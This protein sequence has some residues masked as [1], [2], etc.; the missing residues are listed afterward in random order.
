MPGAF[1]ANALRREAVDR[2]LLNGV[3]SVR[4]RVDAGHFS[5]PGMGVQ[6]SE[7][8][9]INFAAH[10]ARAGTTGAREDFE[11]MLGLLVRA[12]SG[13]AN[14]VFANP[15]DW[16]IDVVVG[17][18]LGRVTVWQA[19][20]F[21]GGV[22]RR[23]QRQISASFDSARKAAAEH[24]YTLER[25]VLCI[26]ASMDGLTLQWWHGWKAGQEQD[27]GVRI[28]LWDE[29]RLRELLLRP[30]AA[31][32][33][34]HYYNP[35]RSDG[36]GD[37]RPAIT[38]PYRGL[39]AF[40]EQD[41]GLFFGRDT[42]T[43]EVLEGMSA[44]L[45]GAGLIV[46]SGVSGAGKSSLLRA[47][48]LPRLRES[49]LSGAAQAASWPCVVFTPG[50]HPLEELAVR[51]A[52]LAGT[53]AS[54]V[55]ERLVADP[56][57]FALTA[58]QAALAAASGASD[59]A[60]QR[61]VLLVID[62]C[63]QLYTSCEGAAEREAFV[64]A[65]H[66]AATGDHLGEGPAALVVLVVRADFEARL[67]DYSQLITAVQERYL[68]TAMTERQLRLAITQ[69]AAA[70]GS[71]VEDDLVQALL[72]EVRT[73]AAGPSPAGA[74]GAGVLPLLSHA[75]DQAWRTRTGHALTLGDYE[76]IGG[77]EGAVAASAQG[78]YQR[79]SP[80]QQEV[81][82][83]VFTRLTATSSDGTDT[84]VRVARPDLMAGKDAAG[85]RD[86]AAV[87][88]EFAAARL[89]VLHADA[90]EIS[91]EA[92]LTAWPLL[93]DD[94][95]AEAHADRVVRT[96]LHATAE[97]WI[98]GRHDPSYLYTGSLLDVAAA[99]A[100][101][102]EAD[103]R[104]TPLGR[105]ERDFLG[106][107][108]KAGHRRLRRR[109]GVTTI[110]LALLACLAVVAVMA[111]SVSQTAAQRLDVAISDQLSSDSQII[112]NDNATTSRQDALAAWA[113]EPSSAQ[114]R[115]AVLK[116]A[117]NPQIATIPDGNGGIGQVAFSPDGKILA[118]IDGHGTADLFSVATLTRIGTIPDVS[119][120]TFSPDSKLLAVTGGN[121]V[122]HLWNVAT[123]TQ[124]GTFGTPLNETDFPPA[125]A[126][127]SPDGHLLAVSVGGV[128][129]VWSI[130][131]RREVQ[132]L[133][134]PSSSYQNVPI[135]F[136]PGRRML[137]SYG[138]F[139][140]RWDVATGQLT[141]IRALS[142]GQ[143]PVPYSPAGNTLVAQDE[144]SYGGATGDF[145]LWDAATG[146]DFGLLPVHDENLDIE[147]FA[148]SP[149]GTELATSD[150]SAG[151]VRLWAVATRTQIGAT[152][153]TNAGGVGGLAFSP[154]G[155]ILA[156]GD[157]DGT[158][159]LWD[160]ATD[161]QIL[162][163][164]HGTAL[165][166][167]AAFERDGMVLV[168]ADDDGV[169]RVWDTT[170]GNQTTADPAIDTDLGSEDP[171]MA[172]INQLLLSPDG[173]TM[174]FAYNGTVQLWAVGARGQR[175]TLI[176]SH[177]FV[178]YIN[179]IAFSPDS[180]TLAIG[181]DHGHIWLWDVASDR[182]IGTPLTLSQRQINALA[183]SQN[184]KLLVN[185]ENSYQIHLWDITT[186][187]LIGSF[188]GTVFDY[189]AVALSPDGTTLAA[190]DGNDEVELWDVSTHKH[191]GS[192]LPVG[193]SSSTELAFS[194]DGKTLAV[195][196][197]G[198]V[199]LWDVATGQQIGAALSGGGG[200]SA[201]SFS[202]DGTT[203]VTGDTDGAVQ[204]WN[205]SYLA[206]PLALICSQIGGTLTPSEWASDVP[207]GPTYR[208]V[209]P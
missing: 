178:H 126:V 128:L 52:P 202:P 96:R 129:E 157:A 25:W 200:I 61:R 93:R 38:F 65:L 145:A 194:P 10:Q 51:I 45:E 27:T 106:A 191:I 47:G 156:T 123:R 181:D 108:Q 88:E 30:E 46:V 72:E 173:K 68:L 167:G 161:P 35:Y 197:G 84:A 175:D 115:Y 9:M 132:T 131:A 54:V 29:T 186:H 130:P 196:G 73:S 63:E 76:R 44:R 182:Q 135:A 92:L 137:L 17:N 124:I 58:R 206:D 86:V 144:N 28:E 193:V 179:S 5:N 94:W 185:G 100:A 31:D 36:Q 146:R 4:G 53:D 120:M 152:I 55:R 98:L 66:A 150:T 95:L 75:L 169:I 134:R 80:A 87:L 160:M 57:G 190:V 159:R 201:V 21:A 184:G 79:L 149:D 204:L 78:A 20:Y 189:L 6:P 3:G 70:A 113:I 110:L 64:T 19:K 166:T 102:I 69:P 1:T 172:A 147:I 168:T 104:H 192:P 39:S 59:G 121:D 22:A 139:L 90:V 151:T 122:V 85:I 40:G 158:I 91:H 136:L 203:L 143:S 199:R 195:L 77:I 107:S 26:P 62:Q 140:W 89:L 163:D 209:C 148:F 180:K 14:L 205:V 16:G 81:A 109:Q 112:A 7:Q 142:T 60:G 49:G 18:L 170:T 83:Q 43:A 171:D 42:A 116:A 41:A 162:R 33:R 176:G 138:G 141:S 23:Q 15:G 13:E 50:R 127:F 111:F 82:R 118:A 97:E 105:A 99:A 133:G 34:R 125:A 12:T 207:P 8:P 67:A 117:A 37:T 174:A 56:A 153:S 187:R 24:A 101:R 74:A 177:T 154:D 114:A 188:T 71:R 11:Q 119:A 103:P 155:Q 32:V 164:P 2:T 183:F 198:T 208:N 165:V 48:V